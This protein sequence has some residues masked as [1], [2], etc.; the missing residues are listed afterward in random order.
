MGATSQQES[1]RARPLR[2]GEAAHLDG[3]LSALGCSNGSATAAFIR[4]CLALPCGD[5]SPF[6]SVEGGGHHQAAADVTG[7]LL[8]GAFAN[9]PTLQMLLLCRPAP[10][11]SSGRGAPLPTA[12]RPYFQPVAAAPAEQA[13]LP[14]LH[15]LLVSVCT[16][17]QAL[18][19]LAIR[20]ARVQD[21]DELLPLLARAQVRAQVCADSSATA[22]G[23]CM[24]D[25][26][27]VSEP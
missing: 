12:L 8:R 24:L 27:L 6:R 1:S 22:A 26:R 15:S 23:G 20:R 14:G 21:H 25:G 19:P 7:A 18:P 9:A 4:R 3:E 5:G 10:A 17:W 11:P 2:E 13:A 16:R